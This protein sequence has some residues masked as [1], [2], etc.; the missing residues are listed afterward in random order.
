MKKRYLLLL[1]VLSGVLLSLAWPANGFPFLI[2]IAFVPLLYVEDYVGKNK[3]NFSKASIFLYS[4]FTFLI[5]NFA[6]TWWIHY[7]TFFGAAMAIILNSLFMALVF[8]FYH[9]VRRTVFKSKGAFNILIFFWICFEYLHLNWDLSWSW[10]NLGNSFA[11][12]PALVQ[13]YE[14]TGTMGGTL[15]ILLVNILFYKFLLFTFGI[16]KNKKKSLLFGLYFAIAIILPITV[17]L[18]RYHT[19]IEKSDPFEFVVVQPNIDPYDEKFNGM[20]EEEQLQ[21]MLLQAKQKLDTN[22]DFL[23]FPETALPSGLEENEAEES[24]SIDTLKKL[25]ETFPKLNMVMGASTIKQFMPGEKLSPTARRSPYGDYYD[26]CNTAIFLQKDKKILFYHKS[27]LVPGVEK[28]PFP[29]LLKPLE[30]YAIDL[31]GMTGSNAVQEERTAFGDKTSEK[32]GPVIC[33]ESI[34]GDFVT[35]Y[36][37]NDAA[38]LGII[39]NDGWWSDSP[40]HRQHFQYGRLRAI[41]TRRSIARSANTGISGYFNQ[42]GD[43]IMASIYGTDDALKCTLNANHEVTFYVRFGD[44]I[45]KICFYI[46]AIIM[47]VQLGYIL[48][49]KRKRLVT[50]KKL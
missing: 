13:W 19:Y 31:G 17:S 3:H 28:M 29:K 39:T 8:H 35:G 48:L 22:T 34:Y 15:W 38:F 33:Y 20:T 30:R 25:F 36:V 44:Y 45:G 26:V 11:A 9:L 14:I 23:L 1:L 46:S 32:I 18:I 12:Y 21:K 24:P 5:W 47:L 49:N 7:A 16:L 50:R 41:E 10:L 27:K 43:V 40:G 6:T 42:R 2:F 4:Y 37:R